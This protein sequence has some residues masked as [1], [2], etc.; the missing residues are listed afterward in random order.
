MYFPELNFDEWKLLSSEP[1]QADEKNEHN[2]TFLV[3]E[4][5]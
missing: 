4:R 5:K 1:H 3:Y 2:Y